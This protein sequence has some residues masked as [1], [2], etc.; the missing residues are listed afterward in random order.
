MSHQVISLVNAST[1]VLQSPL[2]IVQHGRSR[3]QCSC[4]V[5]PPPRAFQRKLRRLPVGAHGKTSSR[6]C[7]GPS[8][9]WRNA[10]PARS[11]SASKSERPYCSGNAVLPSEALINDPVGTYV[12]FQRQI[13]AALNNHPPPVPV[14]G[15]LNVLQDLQNTHRAAERYIY[16]T[17][18]STLQVGLSMHYAR[19]VVFG[20]G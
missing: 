16:S 20:A 15:D 19:Q 12:Q 18:V 1:T 13:D 7:C 8:S 6:P 4:I 3:R 11:I 9:L 10:A 14:P 17:I 5:I 2:C